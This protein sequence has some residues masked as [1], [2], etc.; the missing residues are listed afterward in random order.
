MTYGVMFYVEKDYKTSSKKFTELLKEINVEEYVWNIRESDFYNR[1]NLQN[2]LEKK[3]ILKGEKIM[4]ELK[5]DVMMFWISLEGYK[6]ESDI[7]ESNSTFISYFESK[8]ETAVFVV[9][10]YI[11]SVY[12]KNEDILNKA[13][14]FA[15]NNYTQRIEMI[16]NENADYFF[17]V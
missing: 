8:C 17:G 6:N 11:F 12:S 1:E 10:T 15:K 14:E 3:Q 4:E 13:I 5:C 9:D 16:E 7:S 2:I